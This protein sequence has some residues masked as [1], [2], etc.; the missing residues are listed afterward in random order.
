MA[1]KV[2][3]CIPTYNYA[4]FIAAAIESVLNQTFGDFEL[5]VQDDCSG[6][7]TEEVATGFMSDPRVKFGR[8]ERNLGLAQNWNLCLGK[9]RGQYIK[10]VF[11][12]DLL[13][14]GD[15][16]GEMVSSLDADRDIS[17]V[18]SS[19]NIIDAQSLLVSVESSFLKDFIAPGTNVIR[20]CIFER[21]N[22]IG[23][24]TAVMFR[25]DHAA[26]GFNQAYGHLLDMEMWF[27]LLEKGKFAFINRPLCSFRVHGA[28]K[29]AENVRKTVDLDDYCLLLRQYL[30]KPYV[31]AGW[32]LKNYLVN[33]A[34]YQYWKVHK[35]GLL[36]GHEAS[37]R[38]KSKLPFFFFLYPLFRV[39]KPLMKI[40][41]AFLTSGEV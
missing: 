18:A 41:L 4:N 26:R 21:R 22:L 30:D 36:E 31:R 35:K 29:T 11:A 33:D 38:I 34:V 1:P 5:I 3:V 7:N 6:D 32:V 13:A 28:Q 12:D 20:R 40:Y 8:N 10:Y 27:H 23:E 17:L 37:E 14:S 2:S 15:A 9:A 39:V 16:L 25:K 19:R 24:P